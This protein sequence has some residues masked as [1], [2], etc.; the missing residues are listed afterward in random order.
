ML[1]KINAFGIAL[2]ANLNILFLFFSMVDTFRLSGKCTDADT[3]L[4][5]NHHW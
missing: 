5:V 3:S 2:R 4:Q 1:D